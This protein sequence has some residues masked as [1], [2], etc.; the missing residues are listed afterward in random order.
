MHRPAPEPIVI[1]GSRPRIFAFVVLLALLIAGGVAVYVARTED[2]RSTVENTVKPSLCQEG[3]DASCVRLLNRLCREPKS[4]QRFLKR[5]LA[6]ATPEQS[7]RI[8]RVLPE[9]RRQLEQRAARG[10]GGAAREGARSP[11][12]RPGR[13][14]TPRSSPDAPTP[15]TP[16][17]P[18]SSPTAPS[19]P[20]AP[21]QSPALPQAPHV[22]DTPSVPTPE[23]PQAPRLPLVPDL[24]PDL[25]DGVDKT[26]DQVVPDVCVPA[27]A[28]TC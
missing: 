14:Q 18:G 11:R 20:S 21:N 28:I 16:E 26:L 6:S 27:L 3:N 23:V 8:L 1:T 7:R 17:R 22:P 5:L 19:A 13:P 12:G 15:S 4:C 25:L 2:T 9:L 10:P 24:L